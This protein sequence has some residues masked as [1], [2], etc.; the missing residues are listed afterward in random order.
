MS[1]IESCHVS[2]SFYRVLP[3]FTGSDKVLSGFDRVFT[4]FYVGFLGFAWFHGCL[5]SLTRF[6][7]VLLGFRGFYKVLL[8][9]IGF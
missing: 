8:D 2:P 5:L 9:F 3:G 6:Y 7:W 1:L 4:E